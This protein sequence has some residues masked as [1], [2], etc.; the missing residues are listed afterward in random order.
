MK[1]Y[2]LPLLILTILIQL[3]VPAYFVFEKY[4]TLKTGKEYKFEVDLYDPYDTFRGRYV[5]ITT[6]AQRKLYDIYNSVNGS[7]NGSKYGLISVDDAG[8]AFIS[9]VTDIKPANGDYVKSS[10]SRYF[11]L[12]I[13]RYYSDENIAP[14]LEQ[15]LASNRQGLKPYVI[16]RVKDGHAVI[17]GLYIDGVKIEEYLLNSAV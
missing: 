10:N 16:L 13:E 15:F 17:Q 12:P 2:L 6:T 5:A 3:F 11:T 14:Q 9:S 1:K 4:D 7:K 8:F